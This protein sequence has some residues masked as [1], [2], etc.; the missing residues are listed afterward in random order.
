VLSQHKAKT[1][2]YLYITEL[3]YYY[4]LYQ[5]L[6]NLA[7]RYNLAITVSM[8]NLSMM[9][10]W[11]D[12]QSILFN[13]KNMIFMP[14]VSINDLDYYSKYYFNETDIHSINRMKSG[15]FYY[16]LIDTEVEG[17]VTSGVGEALPLNEEDMNFIEKRKKR[18]AKEFLK[19]S[20]K[21]KTEISRNDE[22]DDS[23]L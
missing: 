3:Y 11:T 17:C 6:F 16:Y 12:K 4:P 23:I 14:G 13:I 21:E 2:N 1:P 10:K 22:W 15:E 9:N 18:Y 5:D 8:P 20:N 19:L 7:S